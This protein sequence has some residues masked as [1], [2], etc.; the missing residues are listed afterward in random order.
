M[1][2]ARRKAGLVACLCAVM[3]AGR[4]VAQA[5][6][7]EAAPGD[8][9]D[10]L[11]LDHD[12]TP[13]EFVRVFLAAGVVYRAELK[14]PDIALTV[15]PRRAGLPPV[16]VA[17][18]IDAPT[19]SGGAVYS[20]RPTADGEYEI[21][22]QAEGGGVTN[23]QLY[24]DIKASRRRQK[25]LDTPG[26]EIG[27]EASAGYHSGY[28][29]EDSGGAGVNVEGCFAARTGP[30]IG[31]I[32]SGCVFGIGYHDRGQVGHIVWFFIE[33]RFRLAGGRPRGHSNTEGGILFRGALGDV[34]GVSANPVLLAPG[35]YLAR[36]LRRNLHGDGWSFTLAD[37]LGF[38]LNTGSTHSTYNQVSFSIGRFW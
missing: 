32:V 38:L 8:S 11:V 26:W 9:A 12:F 23:L 24:R 37:Q 14:T 30:G 27:L 28:S 33:P 22:A 3:F 25:I 13:G 18:E 31:R 6:P 29:V 16:F 1:T 15:S 34:S 21:R 20:L 7:A 19:A 5:R 10:V 36:H 35:I 17:R 2:V 4:S